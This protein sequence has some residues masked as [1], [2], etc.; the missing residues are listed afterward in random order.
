MVYEG[1]GE[2]TRGGGTMFSTLLGPT[3]P[4]SGIDRRRVFLVLVACHGHTSNF[5]KSLADRRWP[6]SGSCDR[7]R[8]VGSIE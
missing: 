7:E 2:K 1:G 5:L 8:M 4:V 3:N 6:S